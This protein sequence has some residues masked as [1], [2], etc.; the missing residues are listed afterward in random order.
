[1]HRRGLLLGSAAL[2]A[3][4]LA[5]AQGTRVLKF[6]PQSDLGV[7]DPIWTSAYV[8]RNHA[9]LIYD[10]LY[11]M[12]AQFRIQPQ[13]AA[14]HEVSADGLSWTVTLRDGLRWH[15]G[16]PVRAAD[17][18]ASIQR[19]GRRDGFG[20]T[21]LAA[22]DD[23][24]ALDDKRLRFRLK[25]RFPLLTYALGKPGSPICA[26]M[27]ERV[28]R[29]DPFQQITDFTG[30]G[31]FRFKPEERVAGARVVYERNAAYLPREA[32]EASFTAGPKRVHFDRVEWHVLPDPSTAASALRAGEMDW[33]EAPPADLVPLLARDRKL[34]VSI[35]DQTG[36]IAIMRANHLHPPFANPAIRRAVLPALLQSDFMR[37]AAGDEPDGWHDGVGFFCPGTPMASDAGMAALTGPRDLEAAKRALAAAGYKGEK[38][39]VPVPTDFPSLKALADVGTDLLKRIGFNVD[40]QASDW[41]TVLQRLAKQDPVEQGGWSM[42]FT[43]WSGLD[44]MN[45]AVNVSLRGNGKEAPSRGWPTSPRLEALREEWLAAED[46]AAQQRIAVAMQRQA[47]EDLPYVPLGQMMAKTAHKREIVDLLSGFALFWNLRRT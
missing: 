46:L 23:L 18:V 16:A 26:M 7:L 9:L 8:T 24:S 35:P 6:I 14:G 25:R 1:M 3:P 40:Y 21:L 31:P 12:D 43:F 37:A 22:T 44:Q 4:R 33:W 47:F 11:G 10:T 36:Y 42:F 39:V 29:T 45:P 20:Q 30:S 17:C 2:A 19:W 5:A 32:G 28:A 38:V 27:P 41:G 13:M 34:S 15:D